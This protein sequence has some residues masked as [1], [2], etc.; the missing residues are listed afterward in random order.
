[1]PRR[2]R[3]ADF[4]FHIHCRF[5][6]ADIDAAAAILPPFRDA[7]LRDFADAVCVTPLLRRAMMLSAAATRC[8]APRFRHVCTP[9]LIRRRSPLFDFYDFAAMPFSRFHAD[10]SHFRFYT[11]LFHAT[12]FQPAA[13]ADY[14]PLPPM[15]P[16]PA[17]LQPRHA[18]TP[19][20]HCR[21]R[22]PP[23]SMA[24]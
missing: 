22:Q 8:A 13:A 7:P 19:P 14:A 4:R 1:M 21:S 12:P 24:F 2:Q 17:T 15:R 6:H 16:M 23:S 18:A 5:S 3:H 9:L 11:P 20:C 10:C